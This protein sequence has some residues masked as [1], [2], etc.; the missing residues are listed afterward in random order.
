L[1]GRASLAAAGLGENSDARTATPPRAFFPAAPTPPAA[2]ATRDATTDLAKPSAGLAVT[3]DGGAA[4]SAAAMTGTGDGDGRLARSLD[5][6]SLDPRW[7]GGIGDGGGRQ[8]V[9]GVRSVQ[10][11]CLFKQ[12]V[13]AA[14]RG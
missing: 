1:D 12:A 6:F 8:V 11:Q 7:L 10:W 5:E 9:G 13:P 3:R 4:L 2:A 14:D